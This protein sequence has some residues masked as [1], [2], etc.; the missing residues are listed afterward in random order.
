MVKLHLVV[1]N[2]SFIILNMQMLFRGKWQCSHYIALFPI[3]KLLMHAFSTLFLSIVLQS[4]RT[5]FQHWVVT[6]DPVSPVWQASRR[7]WTTLNTLTSSQF[8]SALST[9]LP[10]KTLGM[11]WRTS[12]ILIHSLEP[13]RT[14]RNSW[15]QCTA[16]VCTLN[17]LVYVKM[18]S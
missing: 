1:F 5:E 15:Q 3:K 17:T 13:W 11:M 14:L 12:V 9:V 10:W 18:W 6:V 7:S 8:G 2:G 16:K 4:I